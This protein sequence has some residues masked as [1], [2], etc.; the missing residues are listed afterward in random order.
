MDLVLVKS[1]TLFNKTVANTGQDE[2]KVKGRQTLWKVSSR[3]SDNTPDVVLVYRMLRKM[4][5]TGTLVEKGRRN[6][7]ILDFHRKVV[8]TF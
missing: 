7:N 4:Q 2:D 3:V 1:S 5:Q 8:S 6:G